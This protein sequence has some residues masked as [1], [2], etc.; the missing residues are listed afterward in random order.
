MCE[1][2]SHQAKW[3]WVTA[4]DMHDDCINF[5]SIIL[6]QQKCEFNALHKTFHYLIISS[7]YVK[8]CTLHVH[9]QYM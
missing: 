8:S 3:S 6:N 1:S 9:I 4:Y 2:H 5:K 7:K